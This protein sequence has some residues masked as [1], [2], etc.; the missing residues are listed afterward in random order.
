MDTFC[1]AMI[2]CCRFECNVLNQI[3]NYS[4]TSRVCLELLLF[5]NTVLSPRVIKRGGGGPTRFPSVETNIL[6]ILLFTIFETR[7][8]GKIHPPTVLSQAVKG[9]IK[10]SRGVDLFPLTCED[11]M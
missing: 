2:Y 8:G 9:G 5:S 6:G 11:N 7:Q 1:V 3:R 10:V 4:N